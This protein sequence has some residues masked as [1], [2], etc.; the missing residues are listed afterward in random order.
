M[1]SDGELMSGGA[2]G[3]EAG[4]PGETQ[5]RRALGAEGCLINGGGIR[6]SREY[7]HR[8]TYGDIR[9]ELPFDN[10]VV[11]VSLPCTRKLS[12]PEL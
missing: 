9:A 5:V 3:L 7:R 6:A 8:V 4:E 11:M 10:E 12:S 1:S 2:G